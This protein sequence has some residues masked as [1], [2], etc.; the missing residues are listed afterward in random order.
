VK[1]LPIEPPDATLRVVL[2][3]LEQLH[4]AVIAMDAAGVVRTWNAAAEDIFGYAA[5][6][7][8]GRRIDFLHVPGAPPALLAAVSDPTGEH[9]ARPLEVRACRNDGEEVV[10]SLQLLSERD[11]S[12]RVLAVIACATDITDRARIEAELLRQR[13][14]QEIILDGMPAM[15]WYKDCNNRILRANRAAAESIRKTTAEL[16]GVS[17]YDLYPETAERYYQDDLEVIRSGRPKRGIIEQMR[18]GTG[19]QCWLCTDKIP[20]RNERGEIAGVLVFAVD[21]TDR[22]RAEEAL[23]RSRDELEQRVRERT[24][25]LGAVVEDLRSEIAERQLVEERLELALW[26]ADLGLWDWTMETGR[27]VFDGRWAELVGCR[28]EDVVPHLSTWQSRVHPDDLPIVMK[29]LGDHIYERRTPYYESEHRIRTD[30]G[31]Y[32]WILARGRVVERAADGS[33]VRGTGTYRDVTDMKRVEEQM[34]QQQAELA[35]VLRLQTVEGMATELAH[36]INQPLGAIANFANGL[37]ARLRKGTI[38]PPAMLDAAEQIGAQAIRAAQVL[39]RLRDFIRKEAP[40][41]SPCDINQLVRDAAHLIEPD[42]R[43]QH[44]GVRLSLDARLPVVD[45]DSIQIEQV[46][47]NLLRNGVEAIE[48]KG[49]GQHELVIET[50]RGPDGDVEVTVHDT[51]GGIPPPARERLFEPFFTTKRGGLG[52]GLSISRSIVEAHGGRLHPPTDN[53]DGATFRFSLPPSPL[54]GE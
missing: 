11:R 28:P 26:A 53:P 27:V 20:Y 42:A 7:A 45:A 2:S 44:I 32:R 21:I 48:A 13:A 54:A 8:V 4:G 52:M 14:E 24:V 5:A 38:D 41:R 6:D 36:E 23:E 50:S 19:E 40:R 33:P 18:T 37:A 22:K 35:H 30:S 25:K 12:G 34:L 10:V 43:R 46:I 1:P 9:A 29:I 39:Q 15:V 3:I 31:D 51:G 49:P 17:V 16:T 47:L